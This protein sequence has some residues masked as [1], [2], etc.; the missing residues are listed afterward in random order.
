[1]RKTRSTTPG[2]KPFSARLREEPAP[3][4]DHG[5]PTG[6]DQQAGARAILGGERAPRRR[7]ARG[8]RPQL[9]DRVAEQVRRDL[10]LH[11]PEDLV[12][13]G[14][15]HEHRAEE[16]G[17]DRRGRSGRELHGRLSIGADAQRGVAAGARHRCPGSMPA[18]CIRSRPWAREPGRT[19]SRTRSLLRASTLSTRMSTSGTK[20]SAL[21]RS[22][23]ER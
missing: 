10:S 13:A 14:G 16:K 23:S 6:D 17:E 1:M 11:E 5:G 12:G 3:R 9:A 19:A 18:D 2:R 8:V 15:Q 22:P 20:R 7:P 21:E 4:Q